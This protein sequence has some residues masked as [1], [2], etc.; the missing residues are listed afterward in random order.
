MLQPDS[1]FGGMIVVITVWL[2]LVG[3]KSP[4]H[5]IS[6]VITAALLGYFMDKGLD[7][8]GSLEIEYNSNSS[9]YLLCVWLLFATTLRSSM[10]KVLQKIQWSVLLGICAPGAYWVGQNFDRVHYN[11][12]VLLSLVI[13]GLCWSLLMFV[14]FILQQKIFDSYEK[15]QS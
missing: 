8:A 11:E 7:V 14:L 2:H 9:S 10:N 3:S 1:P 4:R 6:F 15:L 13:H 12:P 5:E